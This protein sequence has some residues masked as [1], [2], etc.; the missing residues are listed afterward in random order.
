MDDSSNEVSANIDPEKVRL[1][2]KRAIKALP[3]LD[4]P[5][6]EVEICLQHIFAAAGGETGE[7]GSEEYL[8]EL[9]PDDYEPPDLDPR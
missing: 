4:G 8:L 6:H 2:A 9:Y 3:K 5:T 7:P 1:E